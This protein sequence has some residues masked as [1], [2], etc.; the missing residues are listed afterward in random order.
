MKANFCW[1][2][3][4]WGREKDAD[5]LFNLREQP[6]GSVEVRGKTLHV[7]AR[8]AEGEE[9][10]RLWKYVTQRHA[11][12]LAYQEMTSRRIPIVILEPAH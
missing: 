12:Y 7:H 9:Y 5:W 10:D 3:S 6:H 2:A 11:Q 8:E 4:N 1:S